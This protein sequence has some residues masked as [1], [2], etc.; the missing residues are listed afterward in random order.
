MN[1]VS[2]PASRPS[3][4]TWERPRCPVRLEFPCAVMEA[5]RQLVVEAFYSVPRGGV[6]VGGVLFGT[7][8]PGCVRIAA[9]RPIPCEHALG[10]SFVLSEN[11]RNGLSNL[12]AESKWELALAGLGPVGWFHSHT[13][14]DLSPRKSDLELYDRFFRDRADVALILRPAHLES[15]RATFLFRDI[16]GNVEPGVCEEFT[17]DP[18]ALPA[19]ASPETVQTVPEP[20][21]A[22]V[23]AFLPPAQTGERRAG[24]GIWI[25]AALS[26]ALAMGAGIAARSY[27]FPMEA[28]APGSPRILNF[29]GPPTLASPTKDRIIED[30]EKQAAKMRAELLDQR[31]R[32]KRLE[33]KLSTIK[34]RAMS[35]H[36][37]LQ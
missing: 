36:R 26:A 23:P 12:L 7:R 25:A 30:L 13:R 2:E 22:V 27:W 6:E 35:E 5:I 11:D 29:A 24:A 31:L 4:V 28:A 34:K 37:S 8:E 17:I 16:R 1:T 20:S 10:P 21:V 19:M 3:I 15:T 33:R 9:W 32:T 18:T 14:S